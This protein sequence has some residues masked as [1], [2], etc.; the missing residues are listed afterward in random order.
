MTKA[1]VLKLEMKLAAML[2]AAHARGLK[3]CEGTEFK[4]NTPIP[5]DQSVEVIPDDA[6]ACCALGAM[7]LAALPMPTGD[8]YCAVYMGNDA[9]EWSSLDTSEI[10]A[11]E[12]LGWAFNQAMQED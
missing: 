12:S 9:N 10:D 7:R 1:K 2:A 4:T 8:K 11:M 3:I 6:Y 5:C